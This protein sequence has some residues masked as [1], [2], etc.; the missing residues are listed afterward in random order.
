MVKSCLKKSIGRERL[1]FTDI[2]TVLFEVKN[3]LNNCPLCLVYDDDVSDVLTPNCFSYGRSLDRANKIV[4]EIDFG[5]MEGSDL[6]E[7]IVLQNVVKH[8]WSDWYR[9]Q[10][11]KSLGRGAAVIKVGDVVVIRE[12]TVPRHR[13]R[14]GIVIELIKSNDGLVRG[15]KVKVDKTRNVIRR[16]INCL[17]PTEVR[18]AEQLHSNTRNVRRTKKKD[19]GN[20]NLTEATRSKRDAAVAG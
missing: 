1:S 15:A 9:E 14:L 20:N 12:D 19:V 18:A 2:L 8:F 16:P 13:W 11:C 7:K 4:E 6:W 3:V 17:Y 10:S 5:V